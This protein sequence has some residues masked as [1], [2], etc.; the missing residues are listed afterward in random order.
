MSNPDPSFIGTTVLA[1]VGAVLTIAGAVPIIDKRLARVQEIEAQLG[2]LPQLV[3]RT[4]VRVQKFY[5]W[6]LVTITLAGIVMVFAYIVPQWFTQPVFVWLRE[7]GAILIIIW[8]VVGA[9]MY[10]NLLSRIAIG[11]ARLLRRAVGKPLERDPAWHALCAFVEL[12]ENA[13]PLVVD[14]GAVVRFADSLVDR[15]KRTATTSNR[16]VP[17]SLPKDMNADTFRSQVGNCLLAA[18]VIEEAHSDLRMPS[19]EWSPFYA[20]ITDLLTET[21]LFSVKSVLTQH[22]SNKYYDSIYQE[23]NRR[24]KIRSQQEIAESAEL[25]QRLTNTFTVL[26]SKYGGDTTK[27]HT[28]G[29]PLDLVYKR[30]KAFSVLQNEGIRANFVKLGV[31]WEVWRD[32]PLVSFDFPFSKRI[33]AV[34]MD[35]EVIRA[36][37]DVKS[38]AFDHERERQVQQAAVRMII[39]HAIR[40]IESRRKEHETWL[41][42]KSLNATGELF[43][44]WVAYEA[45]YRLWDY[46][47]TLHDGKVSGDVLS[48]WQYASGQV[49]R[50]KKS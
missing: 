30:L 45:D 2:R 19:R 50:L 26:A 38:L 32:V 1:A 14:E 48:Q 4:Y 27:L 46:A 17:P 5:K 12:N 25:K 10:T 8:L 39:D 49:V 24:L 29:K 31:V 20:A 37:D 41:P 44:W 35:R 9:T 34:L 16:A 7:Q 6:A 13:K 43:R 47:A 40:L 36:A 23:L 33:A 28:D 22:S 18:C 3:T 11:G 42:P 15:L 21:E